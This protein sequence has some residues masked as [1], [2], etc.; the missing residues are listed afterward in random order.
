MK[1]FFD[2]EFIED[3]KTI[4]LISIGIISG[5]GREYYAISTDFDPS[6][7]SDWVR[8]NVL[9]ELPPR[10]SEINFWGWSID[11]S[12]KV[13]SQAWKPKKQIQEEVA[14]F[15]GCITNPTPVYSQSLRHRF[16]RAIGF[17]RSG[18]SI[19]NDWE[20]LDLDSE[21]WADY[22]SYDWVVFCQLFGTMMDLPKNFPMWCHDLRQLIESNP[23]YQ[24]QPQKTGLHNA[25]E[26]ARWVKETY[27]FIC[28]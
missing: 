28:P 23:Q 6:K 10:P 13:K 26:D 7:A 16:L 2:T 8:D 22:C 5:D 1:Y 27:E 24:I 14:L 4:D 19:K 25:L 15:C 3:G 9:T 20:C 12:L 18:L 11:T 21:F 17:R